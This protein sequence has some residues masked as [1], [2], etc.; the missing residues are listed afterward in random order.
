VSRLSRIIPAI[1]IA[2]IRA[3]TSAAVAASIVFQLS[4]PLVLVDD[5]TG[6]VALAWTPA[7]GATGAVT[8]R[9]YVDGILRSLTSA[10]SYDATSIAG[11]LR[12]FQVQAVDGLSGLTSAIIE[13]ETR[14]MALEDP[15]AAGQLL[16][17]TSAGPIE[18][19]TD[20]TNTIST[21]GPASG[22]GPAFKVTAGAAANVL[23]ALKAHAS[24]TANLMEWRNSSE[25]VLA[26]VNSAGAGSFPSLKV[27]STN[28]ATSG[29]LNFD[30]GFSLY[31]RNT[32][33][34]ADVKCLYQSVNITILDGLAG[35][36]F[37]VNGTTAVGYGT[38][39]FDIFAPARKFAWASDA[40]KA[41]LFQTAQASDAVPVDFKITPQGPFATATSTNRKGGNFEVEFAAPTNSGVEYGTVRHVFKNS[42]SDCYRE[43]YRHEITTTDATQTTIATYTLPSNSVVELDVTVLAR[44]YTNAVHAV[45]RRRAAVSRHASGSAA[46]VGTVDSSVN[47]DKE[48]G[49]AAA[50][51]VDISVTGA[52]AIVRVTGAAATTIKWDERTKMEALVR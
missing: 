44:D 3:P 49:G 45:Y 6:N 51:D 15:T 29:T 46:L 8:Y 7:T 52:T 33:N 14:I 41:E 17:S 5:Y 31:Y 48:N 16:H 26:S 47:P 12:K 11:G 21:I 43:S 1:T 32:A 20:W 25:A 28:I 34:T 39:S 30:N 37:R 2:L 50:W 19:F 10:T 13:K 18:D 9:V 22:A 36:Y 42:S 35:V 40:G 38:S 23:L 27:G 24:Q 4:G